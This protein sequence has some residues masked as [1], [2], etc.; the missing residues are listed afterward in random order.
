MKVVDVL[1]YF[2]TVPAGQFDLPPGR[3][4]HPASRLAAEWVAPAVTPAPPKDFQRAA[5]T[6]L[7]HAING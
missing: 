5:T 2:D 1:A 4:Q 3:G 6:D 7:R